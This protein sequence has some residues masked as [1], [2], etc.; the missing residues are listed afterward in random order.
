MEV[1]EGRDGIEVWERRTGGMERLERRTGGMGWKGGRGGREGW[2]RR[3]GM[4]EVG[5]MLTEVKV[6]ERERREG[7]TGGNRGGVG[8]EDRMVGR[9]GGM[10]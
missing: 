6:V 3:M 1:W 8:G 4:G 2:E 7:R 10:G 5:R 9:T